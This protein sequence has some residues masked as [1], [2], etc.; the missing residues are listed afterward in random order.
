MT[1][2]L[3]EDALFAHRFGD[4]TPF[5]LGVEEELFVV[6]PHDHR[7]ACSTDALLA[8]IARRLARGRLMGELCDGAVELAT[9][10]C[11]SAEEVADVLRDLRDGVLADGRVLLI[12]AGLHPDT[13]FGAVTHRGG[14]H[15]DSVGADTRGVL[16]QLTFCGTRVHVAMPDP[17]T[18]IAAYN[19]M[20]KW[21]PLLQALGANSPFWHGRDSG[22]ASARTVRV[23]DAPRTGLPRA[24]RP[25]P[26]PRVPRGDHRGPRPPA[27]GAARRARGPRAR[28][29]AS[30]RRSARHERR[31]RPARRR[32]VGPARVP[33]G[34]GRRTGG[35]GSGLRSGARRRARA[36]S[37]RTCGAAGTTSRS[38]RRPPA[39]ARAPQEHLCD[40]APV[41][42]ALRLVVQPK[43][44]CGRD[45]GAL[46]MRG[47]P[48]LSPGRTEA[49]LVD[50][51][52]GPA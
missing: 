44:H 39:R 12:G 31:P 35:A 23:H 32:D 9:P 50:P 47:L 51:T 21:V 52:D 14:A 49:V 3:A 10:V 30:R 1:L 20:R 37:R 42:L 8:R 28:A 27:E 17:E 15:Y 38:G 18:A 45:H 11:R 36:G 41:R 46:R 7:I 19:G 40:S 4:G 43:S 16:R 48:G 29:R 33:D 22:L 26:L 13:A 2:R 5:R 6:D 25:H 34:R 24:F